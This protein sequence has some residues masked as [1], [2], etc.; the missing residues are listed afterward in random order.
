MATLK[1]SNGE[2]LDSTNASLGGSTFILNNTSYSGADI[3]V[4]VHMYEKDDV[5]RKQINEMTDELNRTHDA[6]LNADGEINDL[7]NKINASKVGTPE[8]GIYKT[9]LTGTIKQRNDYAKAEVDHQNNLARLQKGL[10]LSATKVL[11]EVQTLSLSSHRGKNAVRALGKTYPKGYVRGSRTIAG[12]MVF[13]VFN[14]HVLYRFL[15]AHASDFDGDE[16]TSS[17]LDQLPPV[18]ITIVFANEY[19]SVSKM[20]IYGVEFVDEGTVMSIEDILT[21]NT[22]SYVARD[23]D[24][25]RSVGQR[26]LDE[27]SI[28]SGDFHGTKA[29]NLLLDDEYQRGADASNPFVRFRRRNSPF[30]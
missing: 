19:G 3:K 15:E 22:V 16:V 10:S 7:I 25:M 1:S 21:E 13:T 18:D 8:V 17:L 14:E 12:S 23:F 11:A 27:N 28:L 9:A 4:V 26:K 30:V 5:V 20:A 2:E 6:I 29:S 24:P